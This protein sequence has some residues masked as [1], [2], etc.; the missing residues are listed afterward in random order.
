MIDYAYIFVGL[1]VLKKIEKRVVANSNIF[2]A[3]IE[4][5]EI[6]HMSVFLEYIKIYQLEVRDIDMIKSSVSDD[7]HVVVV[8]TMHSER[9]RSHVEWIKLLSQAEGVLH[10]EEIQ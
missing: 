2:S 9:R 8:L 5:D 3:Y 6:G 1:L 4:F 7:K 10:I